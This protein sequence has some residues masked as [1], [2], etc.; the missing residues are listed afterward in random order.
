MSRKQL[1]LLFVGSLVLF[2]VASGAMPILPVYALQLG[3]SQAMAGYFIAFAFLA[4]AA[5]TFFGGW[6]SDKLQRRKL[7]LIVSGTTLIPCTWMMGQ[8]RSIWQFAAAYAVSG[9]MWGLALSLINVLAGLF[10]ADN[11]RGRVF[12]FLGLNVG[13][14]AIIGGFSIGPMIDRWGYPT[15]FLVLS[16]FYVI[17]LMTALFVND[18]KIERASNHTA[19]EQRE[20]PSF[21]KA[22][23]ILLLAHLIALIVNGAGNMGRSLA[24]N[25]LG[26]TATAIT[27][28]GVIGGLVMLPFPFILGWLSDQVGRKRMMVICYTANALC[29]V[30]FAISKSLWHFWIATAFF[31]IGF[32][33]N[34][35][36]NA[37]V[38]DLVEPKALGRGVSLF[39]GMNWIGNVI[40][41]AVAGYAFQNIGISNAMFVGAVLPL[42]GIALIISIRVAKP[43]IAVS[44]SPTP[45]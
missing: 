2:T 38:T 29:M 28:T 37:F 22:F 19:P 13:L 21:G 14:G 6:L 36:G 35:V 27:S 20:K 1:L 31:S 44:A 15:M 40:G 8:A 18:K 5:G 25:N 23:V 45:R 16:L 30:L 26:F 41:L 7:L 17:L 11:K 12:G 43:S 39:Q 3:A 4:I 24:M 33:S 34:S 42:I 9:F 10:A 32:I